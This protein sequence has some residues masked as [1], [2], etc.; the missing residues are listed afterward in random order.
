[1]DFNTGGSTGSINIGSANTIF[2]ADL[3]QEVINNNL[4]FTTKWSSRNLQFA[5]ISVPVGS[6]TGLDM[7]QNSAQLFYI[8]QGSALVI[9]GTCQECLDFQ[10]F[11]NDGFGIF[12]PVGIWHNIV[13]LGQI[14]LKMFTLYAPAFHSF[15]AVYATKE[16]WFAHEEP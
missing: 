4:F 9:M 12:V 16:E 7:H 1:M 5:Y 2:V 6:D 3:S 13:N 15:N 10:S 8:E 11:A 14:D